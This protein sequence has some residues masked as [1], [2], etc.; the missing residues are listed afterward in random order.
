MGK[1]LR[2][3]IIV[4][5]QNVHLT[6]HGLFATTKVLPKHETLIDPLLFAQ[7]LLAERNARQQ[8]GMDLAILR[9]VL[10][11][12]GQPSAEH[13]PDGYARNQSQKAHWERD[14]RVTVT[15]RPLKYEYE[16]TADK[17]IATDASGKRIVRGLPRE[18][19]V[20]VLC[21]LAAV[22]EA[23]DPA[24]DLVILATSDSDLAPALDEVR[25][26]GTAKI[27]T[28]CWYNERERYGFQI[29]PSDRTHP[30]WNTRLGE[31]AFRACWDPQKYT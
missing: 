10:V 5:Y 17:S 26:I 19:G 2:T 30:V 9:Q 12:R 20:D 27:E 4:D 21:A 29:H 23:Q 22:R 16:R 6:G 28:F 8:E 25:R 18:K 24:T 1:D 13:D 31:A 15:L 3:V 14:K 11:F 7:R